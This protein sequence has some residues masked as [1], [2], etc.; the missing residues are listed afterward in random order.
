MIRKSSLVN[1]VC[2]ILL[3]GVLA[4]TGRANL[5]PVTSI[6]SPAAGSS[7]T[8]F[9]VPKDAKRVYELTFTL[10]N[11][12]HNPDAVFEIDWLS[13]SLF[14]IGGRSG[15]ASDFGPTQFELTLFSPPEL[16]TGNGKPLDFILSL[17]AV[18]ESFSTIWLALPAAGLLVHAARRRLA[19]VR[20]K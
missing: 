13:I 18:P 5:L 15:S 17:E 16:D 11:T 9:T 1:L 2:A 8:Q 7:V 10:S 19:D 20:A 14:M 12:G 6:P 3:L 4:A